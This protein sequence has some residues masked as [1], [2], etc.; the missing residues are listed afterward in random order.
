[1]NGHRRVVRRTGNIAAGFAVD[2]D[3]NFRA[4]RNRFAAKT[5]IDGDE[6]GVE[7]IARRLES[8]STFSAAS[9]EVESLVAQSYRK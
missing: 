7:N 4:K 9:L 1:L 5:P 2:G 3:I 8:A 6:R